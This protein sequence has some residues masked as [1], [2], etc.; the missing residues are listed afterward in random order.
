MKISFV[1]VSVS[2]RVEQLNGLI[3]SIMNQDKFKDYEISLCYQDYLGNQDKIKYRNRYSNI[4]IVPQKLGCN[5]ARIFL[6][7]KINYDIYINLDDDMLLVNETNYDR[8][9]KKA[10]K[11]STGFVLTNWARSEK[12][13]E[14]KKPKM[15]DKFVKQIMIYQGGG[16]VYSNKI[17]ELIRKLPIEKTR[18]DDIWCLTAYINGYTNYRY[19]G[20]L[21]L[22]FV[23]SKGG[24]RLFM[25]EEKPK[26]ACENY[27]NYRISKK[28]GRIHIPLDSDLKEVAHKLHKDNLK[29]D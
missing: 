7:Q 29:Y 5:G 22:H 4:F 3:E 23:C 16:M 14:N 25:D 1:I 21:A 24:M 20:S 6:L 15:C 8:A 12:I 11:N 13:L 19:L 10:L 26:L 17:A 9:I 28:V 27:I 18:F 2:D